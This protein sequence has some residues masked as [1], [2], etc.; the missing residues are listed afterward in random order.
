LLSGAGGQSSDSDECCE[1]F[2][3]LEH[4][5]T[6]CIAIQGDMA[7]RKA[8]LNK[9]IEKKPLFFGA[10]E[11]RQTDDLGLPWPGLTTFYRCLRQVPISRVDP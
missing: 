7:P 1:T 6:P 4:E 3:K 8:V 9:G 5:E 2:E 10:A 11:L